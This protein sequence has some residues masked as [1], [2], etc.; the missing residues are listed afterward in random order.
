MHSIENLIVDKIKILRISPK[1]LQIL[2][3]EALK[4][5]SIYYIYVSIENLIVD[6]HLN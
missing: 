6:K 4:V 2:Q 1:T 3:N 5:K